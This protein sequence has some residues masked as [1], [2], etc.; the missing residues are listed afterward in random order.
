MKSLFIEIS[1]CDNNECKNGAKCIEN[2]NDYK[3][4]CINSGYSGKNCE[5]CKFEKHLNIKYW[6]EIEI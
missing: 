6:I 2:G 4:Q 1:S 3:C 5:N